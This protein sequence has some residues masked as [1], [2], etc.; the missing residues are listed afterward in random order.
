MKPAMYILLPLMLA[1][2]GGGGGD[3]GGSGGASGSNAFIDRVTS[4]I[5]GSGTGEPENIDGIEVV[6]TDTSEPVAVVF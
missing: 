4:I 6:A 5:N 3:G 1:G 2:C